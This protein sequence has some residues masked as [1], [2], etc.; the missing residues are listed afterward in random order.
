M[1]ALYLAPST[2]SSNKR[3]KMN[4]INKDFLQHHSR[5]FLTMAFRT[6]KR[7]M[8]E[9]PDGYGKCTRECGDT[10]EIFLLIRDGVVRSAAFETNG[11]MYSVACANTAVH[12]AE[13]KPLSDVWEITEQ[14]I[15]DYL[16]T[17]PEA[18]RHCAQLAVKALGRALVSANETRRNPWKKLYGM[19]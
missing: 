12:L 7:E 18:E 13:G 16:E 3:I 6:E 11:C 15:V 19:K 1:D 14:A 8:L 9:Q 5:R 2:D 10:I 17:L 4:Q